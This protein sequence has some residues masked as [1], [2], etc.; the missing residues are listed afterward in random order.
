MD[1]PDRVIQ[2]L[3]IDRQARQRALLEGGD[4]VGD[5]RILGHRDDVGPGRHD[6]LDPAL[7]HPQDVQHHGQ[8]GR[9]GVAEGRAELG[10]QILVGRVYPVAAGRGPL[11]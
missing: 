10:D 7:A 8:F 5:W 2:G 1:E 11:E 3:A 6:V 9:R 4:H